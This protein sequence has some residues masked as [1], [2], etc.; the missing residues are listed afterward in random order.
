MKKKFF[1][2]VLGL[3]CSSLHYAQIGINNSSPNSTLEVS[4]K[5]TDGTTAEGIIIP[6]MTGES[7][8]QA[9]I[10]GKYTSQHDGTLLFVT[11]PPLLANRTGQTVSIDSRGYYYFD[12]A[13][14]KWL[15]PQKK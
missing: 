9:D 8:H 4:P 10:N 6:R 1:I 11:E 2:L 5:A 15:K 12:A 14:N 13:E 7:L 3:F